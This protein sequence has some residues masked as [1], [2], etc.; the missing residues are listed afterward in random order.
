MCL[1][2]TNLTTLGTSIKKNT[3]PKP[4]ADVRELGKV[5]IWLS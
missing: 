4:Y 5:L 2:I 3:K 1:F